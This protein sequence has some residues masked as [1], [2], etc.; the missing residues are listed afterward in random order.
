MKNNAPM[1]STNPVA[2]RSVNAKGF[3][4]AWDIDHAQLDK[5]R[6]GRCFM[7]FLAYLSLWANQ[8]KQTRE[9]NQRRQHKQ[10]Q[11]SH[12]ISHYH[13]ALPPRCFRI[14]LKAK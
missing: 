10:C 5:T 1:N 13:L 3:L 8:E 6:L 14:S 11:R 2:A 7:Y 4:E 9:H 12:G